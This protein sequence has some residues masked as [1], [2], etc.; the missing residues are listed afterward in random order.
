MR[1]RAFILAA[2]LAI[3][4][5][6]AAIVIGEADDSPGFQG[7][8]LLLVIATVVLGVRRVRRGR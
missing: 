8:G 1:P 2:I 4:I 7:L 6:V 3:A 5:G